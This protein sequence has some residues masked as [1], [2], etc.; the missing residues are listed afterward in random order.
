MLKRFESHSDST[1]HSISFFVHRLI[2]VF[3][4]YSC[5]GINRKQCHLYFL[6][7]YDLNSD[8]KEVLNDNQKNHP[9]TSTYFNSNASSS[10]CEFCT[11]G[12]SGLP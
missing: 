2:V 11:G 1:V 4:F 8:K 5:F 12:D 9:Y 6:F 3:V 7:Y 10:H